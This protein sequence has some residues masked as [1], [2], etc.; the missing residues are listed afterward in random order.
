M[1]ARGEVPPRHPTRFKDL[2]E[3]PHIKAQVL[4]AVT[5]E[6]AHIVDDFLVRRSEIYY[7]ATDQGLSVAPEVA[8]I[9]GDALGWDEAERRRQVDAYGDTVALSRR[10]AQ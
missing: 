10:Y 2:K 5:G 1:G 7:T 3:I 4:F 6:M 9:M 8:R